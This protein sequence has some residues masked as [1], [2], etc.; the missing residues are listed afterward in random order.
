MITVL[1]IF[2]VLALIVLIILFVFKRRPV[3]LFAMP[4]NYR[5]LLDDYIPFYAT[6]EKMKK[7]IFQSA[8]SGFWQP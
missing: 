1:Q 3:E 8:C 5:E 4:A 6:W 2:F 7:I